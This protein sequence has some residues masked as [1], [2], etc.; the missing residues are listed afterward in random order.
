MIKIN[1]TTYNAK[2]FGW[3]MD[4]DWD[5]RESKKIHILDKM[6]YATAAAIF[7][8]GL[9]WS[10]V[11]IFPATE[12]TE[13]KTYEF[14]NSDFS[15]LGDIIVHTDGT[16]SVKMGKATQAELNMDALEDVLEKTL[17]GESA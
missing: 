11:D 13:E 14:D 17:G 2:V 8:D 6:D 9:A 5:N 12:T 10:I 1:D 7:K 3:M 16:V 15:I 4:S